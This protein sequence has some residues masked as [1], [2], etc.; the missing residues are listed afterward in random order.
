M[1]EIPY[2]RSSVWLAAPRSRRSRPGIRVRHRRLDPADVVIVDGLRVTSPVRTLLD[3]ASHL[4]ILELERI[5]AELMVAKRLSNAD[6][7]RAAERAV[8]PRGRRRT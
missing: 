8:D 6:L 7:E 5:C 4:G 1:P 2:I 3:L